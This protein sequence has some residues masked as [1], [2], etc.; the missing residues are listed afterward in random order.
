M[1]VAALHWPFEGLP[2]PWNVMF[3]VAFAVVVMM[4]AW[5]VLL[6]VRG[7][8]AEARA[9]RASV[10]EADAFT[11]VFLVPALNEEVTIRDSVQRLLDLQLAHRRVLVIDDGS[12]DG[13]PEIL[14][15][16]DHP[17]L[18]VLR[19]D[20]PNA[21]TG[22]AA[23]LNDAYRSLSRLLGPVDRA[24]VIT[25][26]VDAD[27][28]LHPDAPRWAAAQFHDPA[29][30]GVPA[31]VRIYNRRRLL[32]WLQDVEFSVYGHLF[33]AGRDD[34]GTA[35][36]G[37][38]GQFNRLAALDDLADPVGPWRDRLTEDQDLG[39]R[40]IL[41]G[42][43]GRQELRATVD[44]QGPPRLRPLLRQRTR[45]SQGNLQAMRLIRRLAHADVAPI[46]RLELLVYLLMPFWQ[47]VVGV[48]LVCAIGLA[49]TGTASFWAGGP[50]WQLVVFYVLAFGGT[51]L[52][53]VAGRR[54]QGLRGYVTGFLVGH[55][56]ALYTWLIWPVLARSVTRQLR[57]D[58]RW[59]R[60]DRV[61][62]AEVPTP[63]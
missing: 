34:W 40:L 17:D 37:G 61:P 28:R 52:G 30:G 19:R 4:F 47:G 10:A 45:W 31:L 41:H 24:R 23:A 42:W 7:W 58:E 9:P 33:Q 59:S 22:K 27:G 12:D 50:I 15:A 14:A 38:N 8:W 39:L 18:L 53:C 29:V 1:T 51:I 56:Y 3:S 55:V 21:R 54:G 35:G 60:T 32:T 63:S 20:A 44:Q 46:A 48:A 16:I 25:V 62:L 6:F 36:M 43:K 2:L 11:W 57:R 13:T 26:V 49:V 5:T